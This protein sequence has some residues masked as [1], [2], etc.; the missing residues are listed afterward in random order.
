MSSR[1]VTHYGADR[2]CSSR[3]QDLEYRIVPWTPAC[4]TRSHGADV[5]DMMRTCVQGCKAPGQLWL[6][7]MHTAG[8]L[9]A[10]PL[11]PCLLQGGELHVGVLVIRGH[12]TRAD[13]HAPILTLLSDAS[14]LLFLQE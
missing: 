5:F 7:D 13:F 6:L 3:P 11:A 1:G 9:G 8:L 12:A 2:L 14:N 4:F 10:Y